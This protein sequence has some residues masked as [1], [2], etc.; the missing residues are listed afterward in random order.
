MRPVPCSVRAG[1]KAKPAVEKTKGSVDASGEALNIYTEIGNLADAAMPYPVIGVS[2]LDRFEESIGSRVFE[3]GE[4][5]A[6]NVDRLALVEEGQRF[7]A[8]MTI[9]S[10]T[11]AASGFRLNVCYRL[12]GSRL[13]CA[14][15]DF[16]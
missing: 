11:V 12:S 16:R 13:R 8:E 5:L 7:S 15:E 1:K 4:Y 10:P 3:P 14:I 2:L 9:E 6:G